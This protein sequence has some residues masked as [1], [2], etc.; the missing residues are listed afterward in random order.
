MMTI[1][2][3]EIH[4]NKR[5]VIGIV[6][7]IGGLL[8]V[9]LIFGQ[10][11]R[12]RTYQRFLTLTEEAKHAYH[13]QKIA[14]LIDE[15]HPEE[16][17]QVAYTIHTYTRLLSRSHALISEC[18]AI[19]LYDQK[20]YRVFWNSF[21]LNA[22]DVLEPPDQEIIQAL[23]NNDLNLTPKRM[24]TLLHQETASRSSVSTIIR[25]ESATVPAFLKV[26][27]HTSKHGWYWFE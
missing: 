10:F 22:Q 13:T 19:I 24:F 18:H 27:S 14:E 4:I 20:F 1:T 16:H 2:Q 6:V 11:H 26:T 15:F 7:P 9:L 3:I 8:I 12:Y 23:L 5:L 17:V 25:L 21:R